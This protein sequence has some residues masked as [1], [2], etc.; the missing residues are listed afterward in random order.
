MPS[1][2]PIGQVLAQIDGLAGANLKQAFWHSVLKSPATLSETVMHNCAGRHSRLFAYQ[3]QAKGKVGVIQIKLKRLIKA[4]QFDQN[5][6]TDRKICTLEFQ[7]TMLGELW[8][9]AL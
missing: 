5:T 7:S 1:L 6:A 8:Q 3:A 4:P 9:N 2:H